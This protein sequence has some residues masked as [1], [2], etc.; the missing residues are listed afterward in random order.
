MFKQAAAILAAVCLTRIQSVRPIKPAVSYPEVAEFVVVTENCTDRR[1]KWDMV[2]SFKSSCGKTSL[3]ATQHA[4]WRSDEP[5]VQIFGF[6]PL[7]QTCIGG[8]D[9]EVEMYER[10]TLVQRET[11]GLEILP[12][13]TGL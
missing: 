9:I 2:M 8:G 1:E 3:I 6:M 7:Y 4:E 5:L 12:P 10:G 11:G 13:W